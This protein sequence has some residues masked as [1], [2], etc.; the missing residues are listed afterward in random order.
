MTIRVAVSS[1]TSFS[2]AALATTTSVCA[3]CI[4]LPSFRQPTHK[5]SK[6]VHKRA[7]LDNGAQRFG[8]AVSPHFWKRT[9]YM[10][11]P[12]YKMFVN[13]YREAWYQLSD[14]E[15]MGFFEKYRKAFQELGIKSVV[16]LDTSWSTEEWD[17]GGINEFPNIQAVM[18]LT[19]LQSEWNWHKYVDTKVVLGTKIDIS[20]V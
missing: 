17:D 18:Q 11:E 7:I 12:I 9:C 16:F 20:N 13:R 15:R 19:K 1:A 4:T 10:D 14:E 3:G 5:P 8:L 6:L 2:P